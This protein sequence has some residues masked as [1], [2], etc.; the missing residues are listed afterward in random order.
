MPLIEARTKNRSCRLS[1][2]LERIQG[3]LEGPRLGRVVETHGCRVVGVMRGSAEARSPL[4]RPPDPDGGHG[5]REPYPPRSSARSRP[6]GAAG[7]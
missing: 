3:D 5:S 6:G 7:Y 1:P 2:A 4:W